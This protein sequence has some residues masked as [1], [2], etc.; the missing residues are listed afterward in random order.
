MCALYF[1]TVIEMIPFNSKKHMGAPLM[2]GTDPACI[3]LGDCPSTL[4]CIGKLVVYRYCRTSSSLRVRF[5]N[6]K[7]MVQRLLACCD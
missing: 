1:I 7:V 5:L 2:D 6:A 3:P 4:N